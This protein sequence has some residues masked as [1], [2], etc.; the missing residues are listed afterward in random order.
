MKRPAKTHIVA[1]HKAIQHDVITLTPRRA[2]EGLLILLVGIQITIMGINVLRA[3]N[4]VLGV[5]FEGQV[6][7]R[8]VNN[9]FQKQADAVIDIHE[10]K[11][12]PIKVTGTNYT[13]TITLRQLG[14]KAN[15]RQ[16]H[17]N[18]LAIGKTGN[19]LDRIGDQDMAI[20]GG[21]NI[22]LNHSSFNNELAK[23]YIETLDKKVGIAPANAYFA[24]ENQNIVIHSDAKGTSIDSGLAIKNILQSNPEKGLLVTLP[25][26]FTSAIATTSLLQPILPQVKNI[27]VQPL[28]ID[29]GGNKAVLTRDQLLKLLVVKIVPGPNGQTPT[30]QLSFDETQ[31]DTI[32]DD[33]V[34]KSTVAA[35]PTIMDGSSV[36]RPGQ[37]GRK[38]QAE[39]PIVQVLSALLKREANVSIA[40]DVEIPMIATPPPA[41][42]MNNPLSRTGT[43]LIRLTF[44][45]G[46]GAYTEQILDVLKRYNV[47]ATFYVIGRNIGGHVGT[48]QRIHNEG[49]RLGNHSFSHT[50]LSRLSRAGILQELVSTQ[51]AIQQASGVTPTAFRPPYGTQNQ[52]VREVA[53]SLGLSVDLWSVDPEDWAAPGT[54]VIVQRVL[55][56]DRAGSIIL[57]HIL[58]QQ[59]VD[60]LPSIIEGIRAQGY[61]LE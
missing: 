23:Q 57:L 49:H 28:T 45:D 7:G 43:G 9:D 17:D 56:H 21:R 61:T 12:I 13:G 58:H 50:D 32:V 11:T 10:N 24:L 46:P 15:K 54:G 47:H 59:T 18:L 8:L 44:D 42:Q 27:T 60:A 5:R 31:L 34:K 41:T 3:N 33:L 16:I 38:T 37:E 53:G 48:L 4:V 35:L 26:K 51:A 6:I 40:D 14:E 1:I 22:T 2:I 36:I 30:A 20:L 29:V 52:T 39:K 55:S 25:V 19:V